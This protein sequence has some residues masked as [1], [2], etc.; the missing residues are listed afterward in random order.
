MLGNKLEIR[1]TSRWRN[2]FLPRLLFGWCCLQTA[3]LCFEGSE[4][5]VEER[6]NSQPPSAAVR[7]TTPV[8]YCG[9]LKFPF[10]EEIVVVNSLLRPIITLDGLFHL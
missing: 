2:L 8:A 3:V 4:G 1:G 7:M 5:V 6:K 9:Y 10:V